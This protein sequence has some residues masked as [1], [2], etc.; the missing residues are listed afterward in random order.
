MEVPQKTEIE[1]PCD[2]AIP[3]L[4]MYLKKT[5]TL[6]QMFI[7]ALF[8]V[9][10]MWKQSKHPS[11]DEQVKKWYMYTMEYYSAIKIENLPFET[12]WVDMGDIMLSEIRGKYCMV[13]LYVE[14]KK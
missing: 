8:T 2:P 1:L 9:A 12:I 14:S 11:A 4:G 5:K 13:P 6:I 7:A 10:K 3:L